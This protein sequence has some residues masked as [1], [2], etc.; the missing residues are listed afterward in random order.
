MTSMVRSVRGAFLVLVFILGATF[1]AGALDHGAGLPPAQAEFLFS[2]NQMRAAHCAPPLVWSVEV[3]QWA[4]AWA[5]EL[6]RD[7][8]FE[9]SRS[10]YGENL[11]LGIAGVHDDPREIVFLWYDE[12][13]KY[14]F[15]RGG[16]SK[17][18]GHFTQLVWMGTQR[19]G[20]GTSTCRGK[21]LWVCQ[22]DP[23][24]NF[25]GKYDANVL[26]PSC[27]R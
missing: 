24:G 14:D 11:A 8:A 22:Y 9:H 27:R 21:R 6:A 13:L 3:A 20:C 15:R 16:F 5:D 7:C 12:L 25:R 17:A 10:P 2:H 18:T 23:P 1:S 4:Q 26:P 19:L